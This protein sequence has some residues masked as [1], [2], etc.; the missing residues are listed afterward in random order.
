M[1]YSSKHA[2]GTADEIRYILSC[3]KQKRKENLPPTSASLKHH[4]PGTSLEKFAQTSAKSTKSDWARLDCPKWHSHSSSHVRR[5]SASCTFGTHIMQMSK[6]SL[7][8][9]WSLSVQSEWSPLY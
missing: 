6:I 5:S 8:A 9:E 3:Q 7:Q 4:V 1:T 2:S